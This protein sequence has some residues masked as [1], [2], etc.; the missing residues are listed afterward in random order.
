MHK[1]LYPK[2]D[3]DRL[4]VSRIEWVRGLASFDVTVLGLKE[5]RKE[6][7]EILITVASNNNI[8]RNKLKTTNKTMKSREQ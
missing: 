6:I 1:T 7:K 2:Y 4:Y 8:N 5:Y 3:L